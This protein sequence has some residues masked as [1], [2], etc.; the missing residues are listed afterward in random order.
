M[1]EGG[2]APLGALKFLSCAAAKGGGPKADRL[3]LVGLRPILDD[4]KKN[5]LKIN[6]LRF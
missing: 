4:A 3:R 2:E 1:S 5:T 6:N